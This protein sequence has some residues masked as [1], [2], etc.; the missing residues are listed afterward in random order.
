MENNTIETV[1]NI[2]N[3]YYK[4]KNK[5]ESEINDDKRKII[6]NASLSNRE[7]RTEYQR[8]K[9]K[10]INC[11]RPGGTIFSS[12][13]FPS[14]L[15]DSNEEYRELRADCGIISDP[16]N[17]DIRIR[18]G[19]YQLLPDILEQIELAIK[20]EKNVII[21]DKNKLLFGLITTEQALEKFDENKGAINDFT[22]LL[23]DYLKN[24]ID[25]TDNKEKKKRLNEDI[26]TSYMLIRQIKECIEN[27][28]ETDNNQFPRDAVNIYLTQLKPLL[29]QIAASKYKENMV[30][31][32]D[33]TK[34]Y[35]LI[36]NRY[37]IKNMEYTSFINKV[38]SYN[39]GN[40]PSMGN[41]KIG[42]KK[43]PLIIESSSST[44][45]Y[46]DEELEEED[47]EDVSIPISMS[48]SNTNVESILTEKS[49]M[50]SF[51]S[52]LKF[53]L[54]YNDQWRK[55]FIEA[56]LKARSE[57]LKC[58]F[59]S[60]PILNLPPEKSDDGEWLFGEYHY[61]MEFNKLPEDE[62]KRVLNLYTMKDGI[63]DYTPMK[64]YMDNLVA[65]SFDFEG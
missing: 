24:Y 33:H 40:N 23:E 55:A 19:S 20:E 8:L 30:Y 26:E 12:K 11:R 22:G 57:G 60:P 45:D 27:Y 3:E 32:N 49:L 34:T 38:V 50:E 5:Y 31:Y 43:K 48:N 2:L 10:C 16:C 64:K 17:L 15:V 1:E 21:D 18:L 28:N 9:P 25:I 39:V 46:S 62:K 35:H 61:N 52:K 29:S 13:F 59:I 47:N 7:K 63:K 58:L 6:N 51:P 42:S 36:Q 14:V 44:S 4:L 37:T 56:C 65:K 54:T 53:A 41:K